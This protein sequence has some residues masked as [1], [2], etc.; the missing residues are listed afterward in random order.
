MIYL[1]I[2]A[3]PLIVLA[4]AAWS[5]VELVRFYLGLPL[6]ME[7]ENR[8]TFAS[9]LAFVICLAAAGS[10][11]LGRAEML[12]GIYGE[13]FDWLWLCAIGAF[14]LGTLLGYIS[15]SG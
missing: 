3:A 6:P 5:G 13:F 11:L 9:T 14:L 7:F 8:G 1:A 4:M 15:R 2:F 12:Q 10:V